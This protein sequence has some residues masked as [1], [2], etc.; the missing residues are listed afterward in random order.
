M[1]C[2]SS[3][4]SGADSCCDHNDKVKCGEGQGD[5]DR[6]SDCAGDLLC[7]TNNCLDF[8]SNWGSTYDCC[9]SIK[10]GIC[11]PIRPSSNVDEVSINNK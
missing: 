9:Y 1:E 6:D 11:F 4:E 7:G 3:D 10:K 8:G 2:N 5:C